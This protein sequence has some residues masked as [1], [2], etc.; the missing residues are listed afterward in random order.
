MNERANIL[1]IFPDQWRGDSLSYLGHPVA[2]TPFLDALA[3]QGTIFTQSYSNC[4]SCIAAR[5]CLITGQTPGST[6][7]HGYRDGVPWPYS[8]TLMRCL[9]DDGYQTLMAGKT[10]FHPA[11]AHLGFEQLALYDN[12]SVGSGRLS[13]YSLYLERQTNGRVEDTAQM[14]ES[15]GVVV[16][17]W[18]HDESL[19]ANSWT[20]TAA[21]E[22]LERRDPTRPFFLK[23]AFHRPH[24][25]LDPP[26]EY[27][28]RFEDVELPPVPVG[29]WVSWS[30]Q[31]NWRIDLSRGV[32]PVRLLE[33]ARRAYYAQINHLDFQIGRLLRWMQLRGM[34]SET[35]V[36]FCSDHGEQLGEHHLFRKTTA[37][38]ASARVPLIVRLPVSW[39]APHGQRREEPVALHD[40][41]PTLLEAAGCR[42]PPSVEGQSLL[43][44][45]QGAEAV[46]WRRYVHLE[47]A[48]STLGPWQAV[49]DGREKYIWNTQDGSELFFDLASDPCECHN[50]AADAAAADRIDKWRRRLVTELAGYEAD[51]LI[52]DGKLN[53]GHSLPAAREWL[54]KGKESADAH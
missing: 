6:G 40:I 19:H 5:A 50:A 3:A 32:L 42:I 37:L 27:L 53:P 11:R 49:T 46:E 22:M 33:R 8:N 41:M 51:G 15:N 21:I 16:H 31:R 54:L 35:L 38:D 13:D 52:K 28:R 23:L 17:P 1:V 43:P 34:E 36:V 44:L 2:E 9:R 26:V 7:R 29:D 45:A 10:H 48:G 12:Q 4:P 20:V 14:L 47:H 18:T 30:D 25:P 39:Q 24:P